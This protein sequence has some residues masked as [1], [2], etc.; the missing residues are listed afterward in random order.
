[1]LRYTLIAILVLTGL[2]ASSQLS[3]INHYDYNGGEYFCDFDEDRNLYM[4]SKFSNGSVNNS[5]GIMML[6]KFS[7]SGKVEWRKQ[8]I[9]PREPTHYRI[10]YSNNKLYITGI[11]YLSAFVVIISKN[12][13]P[14]NDSR[15]FPPPGTTAIQLSSINVS[16][17][18]ALYFTLSHKNSTSTLYSSELI[19]TDAK[20]NIQ[21]SYSIETNN[22]SSE[23]SMVG[24]TLQVV[25]AKLIYGYDTSAYHYGSNF[26]VNPHLLGFTKLRSG[27]SSSL[28]LAKMSSGFKIVKASAFGNIILQSNV[29]NETAFT[30]SFDDEG[31]LYMMCR[32][33]NS[34]NYLQRIYVFN[35]DLNLIKSI[36]IKSDSLINSIRLFPF[37]SEHFKLNSQGYANQF[38]INEFDITLNATGN[39]ISV[40]PFN[41]TYYTEDLTYSKIAFSPDVSSSTQT[42]GF[43]F[44]YL[45]DTTINADTLYRYPEC[46][47]IDFFSSDTVICKMDPFVLSAPELQPTSVC[48]E[49]ILKYKWNNNSI[50][51]EISV[52]DYGLFKLTIDHAGCVYSDS[53]RV[54]SDS[55]DANFNMNHCFDEGTLTLYPE[56]SGKWDGTE[57]NSIQIAKSGEYH[58]TGL[59]NRQCKTD[60]YYTVSEICPHMVYIPNSF[61]PDEDGY[62]E[63][64]KPTG[65]ALT[66]WTM[67]IYD[68]WGRQVW[69]GNENSLGWDGK[70][71]TNESHTGLFIFRLDYHI[72]NSAYIT[73]GKIMLLR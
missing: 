43:G 11:D 15:F 37:C 36:E 18:G 71:P 42:S 49:S 5:P 54:H 40:Q 66:T 25:T 67:S 38:R 23:L 32:A 29:Y 68:R 41:P 3:Y 26:A 7:K 56:F 48:G 1:M 24:D 63:F 27:K 52:L 21:K 69:Q 70:T 62:N 33:G 64:F 4:L 34:P 55:V 22:S 8:Y 16:A 65:A 10:Y 20:L 72:N 45:K 57:L 60:L 50:E 12:G 17:S 13:V 31:N 39:N 9:I 53:I 58:F 61:T 2:S 30:S 46:T 73:S 14:E 59:D 47:P 44:H 28:L 19:T 6:T 35:E 51:K